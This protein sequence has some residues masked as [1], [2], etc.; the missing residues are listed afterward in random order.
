MFMNGIEKIAVSPDGSIM[1]I[2]QG[3][4][5]RAIKVSEE[6]LNWEKLFVF[7]LDELIIKDNYII[8]CSYECGII[9]IDLANGD[10]KW[11]RCDIKG[12]N[13]LC[14][15]ENA[16]GCIKTNG[17]GVLVNVATGS[18]IEILPNISFIYDSEKFRFWANEFSD[19]YFLKINSMP[20]RQY[21]S[22]S[23]GILCAL[24][25]GDKIFIA[26]AGGGL[27]C[28][29]VNSMIMCCVYM[30]KNKFHVIN[31][32]YDE[33]LD[34]YLLHLRR[35]DI[36]DNDKLVFLDINTSVEKQVILKERV[37]SVFFPKEKKV[38]CSNGETFSWNLYNIVPLSKFDVFEK[39]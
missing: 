14:I 36:A 19:K 5:L 3:N 13:R 9:C 35:F 32:I 34:I 18:T 30:P 10:D 37:K 28:V 11:S 31:F 1:I 17:K 23:F 25:I 22:H 8:A 38:I 12:V 7:D 2:M 20:V 6:S 29:C 26:E 16:V 24:F 4:C 39:E 21:K 33:L 27:Y 15:S